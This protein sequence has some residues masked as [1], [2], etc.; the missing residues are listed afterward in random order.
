MLAPFAVILLLTANKVMR[1]RVYYYTPG[2]LRCKSSR[3]WR[4]KVKNFVVQGTGITY[5]S[6]RVV[7]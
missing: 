3:P 2:V 7:N 5:L 4:I 6:F 1:L